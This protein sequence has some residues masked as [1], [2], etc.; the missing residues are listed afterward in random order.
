MIGSQVLHGFCYACFFA[1][2]YIYVDKISPPDVRHSAQTVYG[3]LII[4]IGPICGGYLVGPLMERFTSTPAGGSPVVYYPG[5]WLTLAVIG[6]VTAILT[7]LF[8]RDET[9]RGKGTGLAPGG[10][11]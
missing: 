11:A 6:L 3:M 2:S 7:V 4:G 1:A 5:L 8:F 9:G 10:V